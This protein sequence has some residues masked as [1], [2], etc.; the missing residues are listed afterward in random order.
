MTPSAHTT[1][2]S[3]AALVVMSQ[4]LSSPLDLSFVAV[5]GSKL[6]VDPVAAVSIQ[7]GPLLVSSNPLVCR[8][9]SARPSLRMALVTGAF[10]NG[11]IPTT[12]AVDVGFG[13]VMRIEYR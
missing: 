1:P 13:H 10:E 2:N 8:L 11:R 5:K 9:A 6:Y 3:A 7:T 12:G 4:L